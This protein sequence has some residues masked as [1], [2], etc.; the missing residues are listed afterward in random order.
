MYIMCHGQCDT[1]S[2]SPVVFLN[3]K[4]THKPEVNILWENPFTPILD[5][6]FI[7][8][9]VATTECMGRIVGPRYCFKIMHN[10]QNS[11]DNMGILSFSVFII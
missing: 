11:D 1:Y 10:L 3:I 9:F 5:I 7:C 6:L 8:G 4:Y 2:T